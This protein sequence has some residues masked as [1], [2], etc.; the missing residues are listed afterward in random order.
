[1]QGKVQDM[2]IY[3]LEGVI[4]CVVNQDMDVAEL[5]ST[6]R[7]RRHKKVGVGVGRRGIS[8]GCGADGEVTRKLRAFVQSWLASS[9]GLEGRRHSPG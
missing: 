8:E 1:M 6:M 4:I 7:R 5:L 3:V 9:S 2:W